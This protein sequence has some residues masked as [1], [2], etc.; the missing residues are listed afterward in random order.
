MRGCLNFQPKRRNVKKAIF[1]PV[2]LA[3]LWALPALTAETPAVGQ[4]GRVLRQTAPGAEGQKPA[5]RPSAAFGQLLVFEPYNTAIGATAPAVPENKTVATGATATAGAAEEAK[6]APA[7][8]QKPNAA[9]K[10]DTR[11]MFKESLRQLR[12]LDEGQLQE[13]RER[14]AQR[15]RTLHEIAS[16]VNYPLG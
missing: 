13:Y 4:Q 7:P 12:P 3:L 5:S 16:K 1:L 15:E 10:Q 9:P 6:S 8:E 2:F 11:A 14:S